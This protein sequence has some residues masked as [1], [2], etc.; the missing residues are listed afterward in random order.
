MPSAS[1]RDQHDRPMK[2]LGQPPGHD[3]DH[4]RMPAAIGQHQRRVSLGIELFG[5]LLVGGQID[6]ALQALA[7]AVE[8][9]QIVG[10]RRGPFGRV[11]R[12]QFDAQ[13]GLTQPAGGVQ[14]RRQREARCPRST[15]CGFCIERRSTCISAAMPRPGRSRK[16][17]RPC[18]TSTRFSSTSGTTSATV[19]SATS[20]TACIRNS[21]I[22]SPTFFAWLARWHRAQASLKATPAPHSPANG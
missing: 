10:Q 5:G 20:P 3:A 18:R 6:A 1:K 8:L 21:R 7:A 4:A 12:Q 19:P 11:G 17:A 9:V 16:L 15:S 14:P 22:R 2:F 13:R